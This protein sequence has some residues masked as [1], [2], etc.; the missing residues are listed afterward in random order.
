MLAQVCF[1]SFPLLNDPVPSPV[2]TCMFVTQVYLSLIRLSGLLSALQGNVTLG[3]DFALPHGGEVYNIFH[4][5][6]VCACVCVCVCVVCVCVCVVCVCVC[7]CVLVCVR[8]RACVCLY[9]CACV[10]VGNLR[11][12]LQQLRVT[13]QMRIDL[14]TAMHG[15]PCTQRRHTHARTHSIAHAR[16][17]SIDPSVTLAVRP[18]GLPH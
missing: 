4:P 17:H 1:V 16:T 6:R 2:L 18:A 13:E 10:R 15:A 14:S 5:V 9:I 12:E 8:V 7:V 11:R 3:P